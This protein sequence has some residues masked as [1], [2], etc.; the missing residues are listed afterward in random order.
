MEWRVRMDNQKSKVNLL[1]L[2]DYLKFERKMYQIFGIKLGRPIALKTIL[3]FFIFF[4]IELMIY[5]TPYIGVLIHWL[6][7]AYLILIPAV[8]AY[9]LSGIRTEGRTPVAFF[10]SLFLYQIRK[11]KSVTYRRGRE[12]KKPRIYRFDGYSTITFAEDRIK[13]IPKKLKFKK[14]KVKVTKFIDRKYLKFIDLK[15]VK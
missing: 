11:L 8:L 4:G 7:F 3:Y 5:F 13:F 10:R 2:N 9:L 12:L 14:G 6:P 1:V 15:L